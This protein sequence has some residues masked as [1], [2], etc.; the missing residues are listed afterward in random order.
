MTGFETAS[1]SLF[2]IILSFLKNPY[3]KYTHAHM[4][5]T[6]SVGLQSTAIA[7]NS[8]E[9]AVLTYESFPELTTFEDKR[10]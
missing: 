2:I 7:R 9:R 8:D 1:P 6:A 3:A 5:Y 4:Q 10:K